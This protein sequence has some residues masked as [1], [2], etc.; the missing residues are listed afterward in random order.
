MRVR[1]RHFYSYL[2]NAFAMK[3]APYVC[4][5][6]VV[7]DALAGNNN[8]LDQISLNEGLSQSEV[9]TI[10]Q[11]SRGYMW[12]GTQD[13]LNR[14][15]GFEI[16]Q[17]HNDPFDKQTLPSDEIICLY[18]DTRKQ[19]WV[20]TRQ[21][22]CVYDRLHDRFIRYNHL[23]SKNRLPVITSIVE[24]S[25]KTLWIGTSSGLWRFIPKTSGLPEYTSVYYGT[26]QGLTHELVNSLHKDKKG[27]IWVATASGLNRI[28][29]V[30]PNKDPQK[31]QIIFE[32]ATNS[33]A[34]VYQMRLPVQRLTSTHEHLWATSD[35]RLLAISLH[36]FSVQ[37]VCKQ[38][39]NT[40]ETITALW[41]DQ[42]GVLWIGVFGN[43]LFR[44]QV[45]PQAR[46]NLVEHIEEERA[47]PNGL[48]SGTVYAL[49]EGKDVN[50]D[51]VW[52]GT[53]EAGVHLYSRS[54]NSFYQWGK[55]LSDDKRAME[56]AVFSVCTDSFGYLWVG[57]FQGLF[58]ITRKTQ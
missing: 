46:L 44:Y 51:I 12:F 25:W 5:I 18:E 1:V 42:S 6:L 19:V 55:L 37:D 41:T 45:N 33:S 54:K 21:G 17:F 22:I 35:N 47:N 24:D 36:D 7:L 40:K 56:A 28:T 15:D 3:I 43:G 32:N 58:Q 30:A 16:K 34:A 2:F 4:W 48:K 27:R 11:D 20:G 57:T 38:L 53:R 39:T 10:V 13:G 23:L 31:Q 52:V 49:Y 8:H 29:L 14:Y 9:R 50:E 26:G